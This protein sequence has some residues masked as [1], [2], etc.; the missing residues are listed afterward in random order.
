M[1]IK[2]QL[3]KSDA[4]G[5]ALLEYINN[6]ATENITVISSITEDDEIPISYFFRT[7]DEL[8]TIEKKALELCKGKVLDVGSGSGVHALMLQKKKIE[9][10][11][12]DTSKGAVETMKKR[13]VKNVLHQNFFNLTTQKF[14][15]LLFLMNG[16][17]IAQTLDGLTEF[18]EQCKKLLATNGQILLDSSDI[19]YMFTEEDG[20]VWLDLNANYY[21][22]VTY[23]M[24][25]KRYKTEPFL[26]LFVD[27]NTLKSSAKKAGLTCEL[28]YEGK[29]FDY[30]AKITK[31]NQINN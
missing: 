18:F 17:G 13:G 1:S 7:E 5:A 26:W 15:T 21:G 11:A 4:L 24:Q 2:N 29:H 16:V 30:L 19:K 23:Q 3:T 6:L 25:Y 28:I 27:F 14:N 10:T 9:V 12:I 22:E 20:S 8:P 31:L